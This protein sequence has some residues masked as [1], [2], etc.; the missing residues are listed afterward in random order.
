MKVERVVSLGS[1]HPLLVLEN[2][3]MILKHAGGHVNELH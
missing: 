3:A 1:G 2:R